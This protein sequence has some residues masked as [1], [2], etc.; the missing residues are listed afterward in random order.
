MLSSL[1]VLPS[2]SAL[3]IL[4][5]DDGFSSVSQVEASALDD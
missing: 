1:A 3:K 2:V 4:K 5:G